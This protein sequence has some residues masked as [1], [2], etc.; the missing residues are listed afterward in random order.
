MSRRSFVRHRR[1]DWA[2]AQ[3]IGAIPASERLY[4]FRVTLIDSEP[5]IWR[6]IQVRDC[7]LDKFHERIQTAMGWTNSHLHEFNING[8][9]Y[10]DPQLLDEGFDH[11]ANDVDST[12]ARLSEIVP[13]SGKRFRF[14]YEYDFGDGCDNT[15]TGDLPLKHYVAVGR[16]MIRVAIVK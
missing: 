5:P 11:E 10:G 4:Q 7:T 2:D 3:G 8:E 15:A 14:R 13:R 9:R 1:K 16:S 12:Q 6:R